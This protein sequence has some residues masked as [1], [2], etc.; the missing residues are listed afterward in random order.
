MKNKGIPRLEGASEYDGTGDSPD[1][2]GPEPRRPSEG[3]RP[4]DSEL[5]ATSSSN[6]VAV[7]ATRLIAV[8]KRSLGTRAVVS[9]IAGVAALD[10][11][12]LVALLEAL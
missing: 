9:A 7:S 1:A 4:V 3:E 2:L 5:S 8:G 6:V 12:V 10:P 11:G